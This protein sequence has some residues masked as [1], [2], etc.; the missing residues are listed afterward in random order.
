MFPLG[1]VI[2]TTAT[3]GSPLVVGANAANGNLAM[4]MPMMQPQPGGGGHAQPMQLMYPPGTQFPGQFQ[5]FQQMQVQ[6]MQQGEQADEGAQNWAAVPFAAYTQQ[7]SSY[8]FGQFPP[9]SH[10]LYEMQQAGDAQ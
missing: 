3:A 7:Y 6:Q 4:P 5:Q 8:L 9:T 10:E 1:P 2:E